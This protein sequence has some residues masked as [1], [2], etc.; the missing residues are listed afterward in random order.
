MLLVGALYARLVLDTL[1]VAF[2]ARLVL[3]ALLGAGAS[4]I[5]YSNNVCFEQKQLPLLNN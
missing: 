1:L 4:S 2:H 3:D 5:K